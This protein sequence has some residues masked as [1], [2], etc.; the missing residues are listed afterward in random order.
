DGASF[1]SFLSVINPPENL[2]YPDIVI[3]QAD[4]SFDPGSVI[5]EG[6]TVKINAT[7]HNFGDVNVT[8]I[9]VSFYNGDPSLGGIL[10]D[11]NVTIPFLDVGENNTVS[12][13]WLPPSSGI[14]DI[15]V[16]VDYPSP[17]LIIEIDETNNLAFKILEVLPISPPELY[18]KA[19]GNDIVLNWTQAS[20]PG[21]SH[22]LIYRST[23][24]T[25]FDFT[26]PWVDTSNV[27]ANGTDPV[28]KQVIPL[29][30]TWNDTGSASGLAPQEFYYI[31]RTVFDSGEI[32]HTSRSVGKDTRIFSPG[33][34][35]FSLP[36]KP[37]KRMWTDDYTNDMNA[38][39]IRYMNP[40][41][42]MWITHK[43]GDGGFNNIVM[44]VGK[45]YEV[46]FQN[47]TNYTFTGM[48]GA[49]ILYDD[50]LFGFDTDPSVGDADSL[51]A[52]VDGVTGTVTLNWDQPVNLGLGDGFYV[53]RSI[54]RDGFWGTIGGDYIQVAA[55][56][57]DVLSYQDIGIATS[58][59]EFYY[60][61]I[62]VDLNTG[63]RGIASYSL[64]VWTAG[65]LAQYDTFA[66]PLK[67]ST[68]DSADWFCD[69]I[70]NTIGINFFLH[71]AQRWGWHST[72]MVKGAYDPMIRMCFGYQ[73]ST[74]SQTK[75]SFVGI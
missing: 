69:N 41:T 12:I 31:I 48:P 40:A 60:M 44:E 50:V 15:Y 6:A 2:K 38:D 51:S 32:S 73:L 11:S 29:R 13:T 5:T 7:I 28:D 37:L 70:D 47:T 18:I 43:K 3:S 35:T 42:H 65:Y 22:Y 16:A 17:G 62:P 33:I 9:K 24:Q 1:G 66:L 57:F 59:T 74:N 21:I 63:E 49:M 72:R 67:P 64:G 26:L 27:L 19:I 8:G 71:S 20:I 10:I 39:Y 23:S 25:G 56:A 46:Y 4:I 58:G 53:L 68:Y 36:L 34:S 52:S 54:K 45:G 75:F 55:L 30:T 14:Y 61:I